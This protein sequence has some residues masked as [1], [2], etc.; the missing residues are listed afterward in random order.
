MYKLVQI[1]TL[2]KKIYIKILPSAS[3]GIE[4]HNLILKKRKERKNPFKVEG[5]ARTM[6]VY[7][8]LTTIIHIIED[9]W[10]I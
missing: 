10:D 3:L 9:S 2:I 8:I 4:I 5:H 7:G 1:T 6:S